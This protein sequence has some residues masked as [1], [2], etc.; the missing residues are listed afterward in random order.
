MTSGLRGSANRTALA[1]AAAVLLGAGAALASATDPVRERLPA[2]WPHLGADRT[3]LDA[4]ALE[5]WRDH[6]WWTAAVLAALSVAFLLCAYGAVAQVRTG[7]LRALPLG[8]GDVTLAGSALGAALAERARAIDGVHRAHV[9]VLGRPHRLRAAVTLVLEPDASPSVVLGALSSGAVAEARAAAA[10]RE[11][12]A[13]V[14]VRVRSHRA[15]RV[16]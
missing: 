15:G 10:P 11:L 12:A 3:W 9:R 7:R 6:P 2:G 16:H 1:C 8:R 14:R 4:G 5:R 13:D